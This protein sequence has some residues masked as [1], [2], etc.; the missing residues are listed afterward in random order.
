M[1]I[2]PSSEHFGLI[3]FVFKGI[4]KASSLTK[5][6]HRTSASSFVPKPTIS[7][8]TLSNATKKSLES[9]ANDYDIHQVTQVGHLSGK[10]MIRNLSQVDMSQF[11]KYYPQL[12]FE[13]LNLDTK[14]SQFIDPFSADLFKDEIVDIDFGAIDAFTEAL[15]AQI[16]A[17]KNG[18]E[19][20]KDLRFPSHVIASN[21]ASFLDNQLFLGDSSANVDEASSGV[22]V[23]FI[24][25]AKHA[26][27]HQHQQQQQQQQQE[28]SYEKAAKAQYSRNQSFG[29][30][31]DVQSFASKHEQGSVLS[32]V[33]QFIQQNNLNK[34]SL[35]R[36]YSHKSLIVR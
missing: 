11:E 3:N 29:S 23:Q 12:E 22:N 20:P 15:N 28:S 35:S 7:K 1:V 5:L 21:H 13:P 2:F 10:N 30:L 17:E 6:S 32:S 33:D 14:P 19:A 31:I 34:P 26:P 18:T 9:L 36:N 4:S 25:P 8:P 16:V 24:S 27:Q